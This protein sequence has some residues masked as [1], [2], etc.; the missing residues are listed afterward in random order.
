MRVS[1]VSASIQGLQPRWVAVVAGLAILGVGLGAGVVWAPRVTVLICVAVIVLGNGLAL[2]RD[3]QR[4]WL[5]CL[6]ATLM[7]Y[8]FL[9]RGFAYLGIF[10]FLIGEMVML[11]GVISLLWGGLGQALRSAIVWA[12]IGLAGHGA[13]RT[14]PYL[15]TF[16][17]D[18]LRDATIW[19]Y[20]IYAV[21]V[22]ATL[23]RTGWLSKGI[24]GYRVMLP[25]LL[26]W[27]PVG[28]TF[29][30]VIGQENL[31]LPG[32][33]KSGLYLKPGDIAVHLAGAAAFLLAGL[34]EGERSD[35]GKLAFLR[36][37]RSTEMIWL[38]VWLIG[39]MVASVAARG[40]L[41]AIMAAI[42]VVLMLRPSAARKLVPLG[43]VGLCVLVGF[44]VFDLRIEL[45]R[46]ELSAAQLMAN[47]TSLA[48][49]DEH[50]RDLAGT[51]AWRLAWWNK[52]LDYTL[53]GEYFW[54]G[55]G[56][57]I[58]LAE[59]DGFKGGEDPPL[60]SPHNGTLTFLARGGAIGVVLWLVLQGMFV[61]QMAAA[62]ARARRLGQT[63][64]ASLNL[65]ILAYWTAFMVNASFDVYFEGPQGGIWFWSLIG[66][67]IAALEVQ[68]RQRHAVRRPAIA[69]ISGGIRPLRRAF[70][71]STYG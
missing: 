42:G 65:W 2:L 27:L 59:V 44:L 31:W 36:V 4:V 71:V 47:V 33:D 5:A 37:A 35:R 29:Q 56:Y 22:A 62:Y 39:V 63:R 7:G 51:V 14:I 23:L 20:G 48:G 11:L 50:E 52:I 57:G 17:L 66:F 21:L 58:N 16:G 53:Y 3:P 55:K 24:H 8:A 12:W 32:V 13:L 69:R 64:W 61:I 49:G 67:G 60:R 1:G 26:V 9:D 70:S 43:L 25:F 40:G 19:S 18:A 68:H 6:F 54:G 41:L 45:P 38:P 10:P 28:Y 15:E 34:H 46:R 30:S